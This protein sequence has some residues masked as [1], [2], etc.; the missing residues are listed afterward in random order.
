MPVNRNSVM[1]EKIHPRRM[2]PGKLISVICGS[3]L[4]AACTE[5]A[6]LKEPRT[7]RTPSPMMASEVPVADW[8][9][10]QDSGMLATEFLFTPNDPVFRAG[11]PYRLKIRNVGES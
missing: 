8:T 10:I 1:R 5:F 2:L 6:D 11:M 7:L 3:L 4:L 9:K